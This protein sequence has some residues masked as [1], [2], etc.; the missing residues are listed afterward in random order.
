SGRRAQPP[1][2]ATGRPAPPRRGGDTRSPDALRPAGNMPS[3]G[4]NYR[5][6]VLTLHLDPDPPAFLLRRAQPLLCGEHCLADLLGLLAR[7]Q[8]LERPPAGQVAGCIRLYEGVGDHHRLTLLQ[9]QRS[10]YP[11]FGHPGTARRDDE[12]PG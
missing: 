2:R 7:Y 11:T 3:Y 6:E 4:C 1:A 8:L 9:P 5:R 12:G 10:A